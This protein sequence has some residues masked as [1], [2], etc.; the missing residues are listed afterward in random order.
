MENKFQLKF[1]ALWEGRQR[2]RCSN[3]GVESFCSA[4]RPFQ[5]WGQYICYCEVSHRHVGD[6]ALIYWDMRRIFVR[7]CVCVCFGEN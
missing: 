6:R 3:L 5:L 2:N 1:V 4:Q 7:A